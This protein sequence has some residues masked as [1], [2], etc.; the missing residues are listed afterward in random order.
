MPC[1]AA[2]DTEKLLEELLVRRLAEGILTL[3]NDRLLTA[4]ECQT[5]LVEAGREILNALKDS[6][7]RLDVKETGERFWHNFL[8]D[9]V[10]CLQK[11]S[12]AG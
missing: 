1:Q 2:V 10:L 3:L 9:R 5:P 7:I 4:E 11:N 6:I 8:Y 12:L